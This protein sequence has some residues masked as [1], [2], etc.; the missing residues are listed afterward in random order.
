[1]RVRRHPEHVAEAVADLP[2]PLPAVLI[3]GHEV[4]TPVPA[5]A[6]RGGLGPLPE[7]LILAVGA[8]VVREQAIRGVNPAPHHPLRL[9][10]AVAV[11][12]AGP[13]LTIKLGPCR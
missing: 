1:M 13:R 7:P 12:V 5:V 4:V 9:A 11:V 2:V 10:P 6:H 3:S 8:P